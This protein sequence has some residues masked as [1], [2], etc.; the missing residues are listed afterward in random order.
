MKSG[1]R[2]VA[3]RLHPAPNRRVYIGEDDLQSMDRILRSHHATLH[4]RLGQ[5]DRLSKYAEHCLVGAA[6]EKTNRLP[7]TVEG[8]PI[9]LATVKTCRKSVGE[10]EVE[11][12]LGNGSGTHS[13]NYSKG[14][15]RS[16]PWGDAPN[17]VTR[18]PNA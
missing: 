10:P 6:F 7:I 14:R 3:G 5:Q 15:M 17:G 1:E 18:S 4:V 16:C 12:S 9:S 13:G 2:D 11:Q 8:T